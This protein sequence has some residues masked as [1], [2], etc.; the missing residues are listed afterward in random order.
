[1]R[2][3]Q[4]GDSNQQGDRRLTQAVPVFSTLKS[5]RGLDSPRFRDGREGGGAILG[6]RTILVAH[7]R[8][9]S[10]PCFPAPCSFLADQRHRAVAITLLKRK[11]GAVASFVMINR[12]AVTTALQ[13][14]NDRCRQPAET[15][16]DADHGSRT[17]SCHRC[18]IR[19]WSYPPRLPHCFGSS[20]CLQRLPR[21]PR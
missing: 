9:S 2:T 1:M 8:C 17:W 20:S 5:E 13:T 6:T 12:K 14:I 11:Q 19:L 3:A 16:T 4:I 7:C 10:Q 21:L 18:S 15:R